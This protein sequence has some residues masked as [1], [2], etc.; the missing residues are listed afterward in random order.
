MIISYALYYFFAS[1]T[2]T[3]PWSTCDNP[4]NTE[5][6]FEP[7]T[8]PGQGNITYEILQN[9]TGA[10]GEFVMVD[11]EVVTETVNVTETINKT[12][13]AATEYYE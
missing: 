11:G 1:F 10:D 8:G 13:S 6:C 4:W 5:F 12:V 2:P 3:L 7:T 9:V